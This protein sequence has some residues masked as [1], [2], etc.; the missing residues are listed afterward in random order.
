M[1]EIAKLLGTLLGG[2]LAGALL[3]EWLRRRRSRVHPIPLI[4]RVNRQVSPELQG[5]TLARIVGSSTVGSSTDHQLEEVKNLREYQ[6][7]MRN[8]SSIHLRDA[9]VQFEFPADDVQAWASRPTLSKTALVQVDATATEP[10]RKAFR[11]RIPHLPS[12][13]AVEFTF[14]AIDPSSE[15]FEAALYNSEGIVFERV[16]G[17]PPP[18]KDRELLLSNIVGLITVVAFMC[19]LWFALSIVL[20]DKRRASSKAEQLNKAENLTTP[21]KLTAPEKITAIKLAGCNLHVTSRSV[22]MHDGTWH[23]TNE[24]LNLG[25]QICLVQSE[26]M[27]LVKPSAVDPGHMRDTGRFSEVSRS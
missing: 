8:T 14:R 19:V 23:I 25:A 22:D 7:T 27:D 12:G 6:L 5:F 20:N 24:I 15:S 2:G 1:L 13:D 18:K 16:V 17:E 21:E 3:T 11:W 10:W 26:K 4:E 9:E